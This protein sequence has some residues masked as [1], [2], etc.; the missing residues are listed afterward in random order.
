[1]LAHGK[2][3]I[4]FCQPECAVTFTQRLYVHAYN[5]RFITSG[6]IPNV[7]N[8]SQYCVILHDLVVHIMTTVELLIIKLI[9]L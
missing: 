2:L 9:N 8:K 7:E 6:G 3:V 5:N 1:M 4:Y